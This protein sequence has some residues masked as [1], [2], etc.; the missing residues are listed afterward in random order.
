MH[1]HIR[2]YILTFPNKH[3][4]I[5]ICILT[6]PKSTLTS[7]FFF[8]ILLTLSCRWSA[9]EYG[10]HPRLSFKS[11]LRPGGSLQKQVG[12]QSCAYFLWVHIV[13]SRH[14]YTQ[15]RWAVLLCC[16]SR[17]ECFS[18][19]FVSAFSIQLFSR[20]ARR[21]ARSILQK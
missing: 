18:F 19:Q 6:F 20:A 8:K 3:P 11:L 13:S 1:P 10:L 4:H 14:S 21:G 2:I 7:E 5:R 12:S 15:A 17:E 9:L 16:A